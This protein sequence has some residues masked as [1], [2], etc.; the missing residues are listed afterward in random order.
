MDSLAYLV[1]HVELIVRIVRQT[2]ASLVLEIELDQPIDWKPKRAKLT[3]SDGSVVT[4]KV[5]RRGTTR[6]GKM[7]TGQVLRLVLTLAGPLPAPVLRIE[8]E[9]KRRPTLQLEIV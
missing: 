7:Q 1:G 4:A 8:L 5:D 6:K 2:D 3:L 9:Q